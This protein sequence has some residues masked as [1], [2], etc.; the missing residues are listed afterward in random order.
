MKA[1]RNYSYHNPD[2]KS[3][4][5]EC[6]SDGYL[7]TDRPPK[8]QKRKACQQCSTMLSGRC[9]SCGRNIFGNDEYMDWDLEGGAS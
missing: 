6:D 7:Y 1:N 4:D 8:H 5:P 2:P 9:D 3:G